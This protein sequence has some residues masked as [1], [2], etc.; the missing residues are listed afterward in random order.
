VRKEIERFRV[1]GVEVSYEDEL[2]VY[3]K[4]ADAGSRRDPSAT[5]PGLKE[6]ETVDGRACTRRPDGLFLIV[7]LDILVRRAVV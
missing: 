3:Q 4:F 1:Q 7:D 5:A 2:V 6:V